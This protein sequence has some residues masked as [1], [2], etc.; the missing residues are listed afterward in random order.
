[1]ISEILL[2]EKTQLA[3]APVLSPDGTAVAFFAADQS[4]KNLLW[5][6][7]FHSPVA[8]SLAGTEGGASLFWSGNGRAL[9]FFADRQLKIIELSGGPP[10]VVADAPAN[11]GGSWNRAGT[12]LF[13][14]DN[15]KGL[16]QMAASGGTPV[17][18]LA[19][20][21]SKYGICGWPK[22]L[23]DGKH[24]L[25][26]AWAL[27]PAS[28]GTYFASL[29]GKENRLL[30]KE[31]SRATYASGYLLYLRDKTLMAQ[32]F[33]PE[34]GEFKGD[35]HPVAERVF[36]GAGDHDFFDAS[37]NGVLIYQEGGSATDR[38]MTWFDRAG[39]ELG[40]GEEGNYQ[41]LRLSPDGTR[42]AFNA[43]DTTAGF[44]VWVDELA[45]RVRSV[46]INHPGYL[47]GPP[48]WS[49]DGS[50]VLLD[51][52]KG[53]T[54]IYLM[55]SN[56]AGGT[57][58]L[59]PGETSDPQLWPTSWSRD[60]RFIL[61]VRGNA[62]NTTQNIWVLPLGVDRKPRL[63]I[64]NAF[65]GQFSPDGRWVSY[66]SIESRKID[67]FVVPFEATKLLSTSPAAATIPGGK[68]QISSRGGF[69]ARW[70]GDGKEIFYGASNQMMAA[71]VDGRTE[72]FQARKERPL[73]TLPE[74]YSW[75]D[76]TPNGKRF[77]MIT[78]KVPP[79]TPL[80]LVVNW[81]GRLAKP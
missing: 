42:L 17:P 37:E 11:G 54:G 63:F 38:R 6:R 25:Y 41:Q 2:P 10:R 14:P 34:R 49:P 18:V 20:D 70:R 29:D 39:K 36:V 4:G 8:R 51:G 48:V 50:R 45:R 74:G 3:G 23:P 77:V 44:S 19:L 1:V 27:E 40:V 13:V 81:P 64:E 80:T 52:F 5:V 21:L 71:E 16:Y 61:F 72:T 43:G 68:M 15:T 26:H 33:D 76:V 65:D 28:S 67:V 12:F 58:P 30:L 56:G 24:F 59:L 46:L 73:F 9:G 79:N 53:R 69:I 55:N 7:S 35:A 78:R 32:P 62:W 60:G 75:Y 66:S 47:Y 31:R 22:F 57:E